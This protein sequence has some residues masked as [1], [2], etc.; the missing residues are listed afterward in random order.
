M[1]MRAIITTANDTIRY[2]NTPPMISS[3]WYYTETVYSL[4]D[5][6]G[7]MTFRASVDSSPDYDAVVESLNVENIFAP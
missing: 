5:D 7:K 4:Y 2:E 3:I 6:S 1:N